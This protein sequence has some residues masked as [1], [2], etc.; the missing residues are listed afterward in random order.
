MQINKI[1][2]VGTTQGGRE[3]EIERLFKS[4]IG[5]SDFLEVIFVDQSQTRLLDKIVDDY[6][7]LINIKLIRSDKVSLSKAR[8][9]AL[10]NVTGN[11]IAFCDDDA[12]YS[13]EV[14]KFICNNIKPGIVF[15]CKVIDGNSMESYGNRKY[16]KHNTLLNHLGI[17]K[18]SLSVGVFCH[19]DKS[20]IGQD[21]ILFDERLGVGTDL[22]GSE[23]TEY[24]FRLMRLGMEVRFVNDIFVFHDNDKV[25]CDKNLASLASKYHKYAIGYAVV[26]REYFISSFGLLGLEFLRVFFRSLIGLLFAE[27]RTV[28]I[29][30]LR[31]LLKGLTIS[32][33]KV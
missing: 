30:R 1:S 6:R 8:N 18:Y 13:A 26:I 10:R 7:D 14:L 16:P 12:Y 31:G 20:I 5:T 32:L 3:F 15:S 27:K 2:L 17:I 11:V 4:L 21:Y 24:L 23:E 28:C 9:I 33:K 29:A 22:G 25:L 19:F